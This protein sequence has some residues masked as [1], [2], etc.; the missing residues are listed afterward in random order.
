M[1]LDVGTIKDHL[2]LSKVTR[3][4]LTQST[5][6]LRAKTLRFHQEGEIPSEAAVPTLPILAW[7]CPPAR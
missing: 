2:P 3:A 5:E 4:G 7:G 6:A 1:V